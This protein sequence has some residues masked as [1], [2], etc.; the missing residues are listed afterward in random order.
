MHRVLRQPE[1][2]A[3][4][5]RYWGP[6]EPADAGTAG[7]IVPLAEL[8]TQAQRWL[9]MANPIG[10][11]LNPADKVEELVSSLSRL[12]LVAVEFPSPG[13]GRGYTQGR[14]LRTRFGFSGELRAV[15]AAVKR[16][17]I[18]PLARCGFDAFELAEGESLEACREALRR[19]SVAY[20]ADPGNGLALRWR[21][22]AVAL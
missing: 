1:G 22:A 4:H 15:G 3:A 12:A 14:L 10:V 2:V 5:W 16:D 17:L 21:T 6:A 18:G 13:E 7:I 9:T 8:R 19:Y 11:R 20:Q